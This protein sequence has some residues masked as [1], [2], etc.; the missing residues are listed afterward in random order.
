MPILTWPRALLRIEG[1]AL[2]LVAAL[3][4]GQIPG[5][6]IAFV[7]LLLAPDLGMLGYL[8]GTRVGAATYNLAHTT[9]LPLG[10]AAYWAVVPDAG[11]ASL[12]LIWL[13]HVGGDRLMGFGLK[14]PTHFQDTHLQHV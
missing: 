6:W 1:G 3:A 14:Y 7:V 4:Y 10:L 11:V 12:A 8:A 2:L 9:V 5:N 13:A